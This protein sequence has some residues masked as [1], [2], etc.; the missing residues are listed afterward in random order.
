[1]A[2]DNIPFH[3]LS[4]PATIMGSNEPWKLVDFIKGFNWLLYEGG[5]FSTSQ[6][7]GV[8]MD[9]ALE[10]LP[11]DYWR[12]WLLSN[13]PETSD[14]D[15]TWESFQSGVNKDLSDVLGNFVSRIT[16]FTNSKFGAEIPELT[17]FDNNQVIIVNELSEKV[18]SLSAHMNNIEIRKACAELRNIWTIGNEYLQT[19]EP[20]KIYKENPI[21]AGSII[22]FSFNLI[23]LYSIIS[24]PFIPDTCNRI[25]EDLGFPKGSTW[26]E[27]LDSFLQKIKGGQKFNVPENLFQ[28]IT[29]EERE[30]F[31]A[32]FSG[33]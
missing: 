30:T 15:F 22:N 17:K 19:A 9:Q 1:M 10:L 2:K 16:K 26:P 32:K 6:G 12:W 28:K 13:A 8:F 11:S 7:R 14:S 23:Y 18:S 33:S 21:E 27:D 4:F 31:A 3:T 20:W 5:K 25:I 24:E 29:D